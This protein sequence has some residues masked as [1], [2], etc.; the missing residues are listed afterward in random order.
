VGAVSYL[1]TKP[2]LYGIRNHPVLDEITL[3]E[4]YPSRVAQMLM[5]GRIDVGLIPVAATLKLP[6]WNI[7][8]SHCIGASGPVASVCLFSGQP[9][10]SIDTV[11]LDYQSRTSVNLARV[12]LRE[13]WKKDVQFIDA[14]GEDFRDKIRG[15]VA[16]VI[17]GD[18]ALEQRAHSAYIYDL[19]EAWI[20]HTGLPF[21][22]AAWISARPLPPSFCEAFDAANALGLAHLDE[23]ISA[24]PFAPYDLGKYYREN[25]DY[26]LDAPKKRG[27]QLF[28]EK[29]KNGVAV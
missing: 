3:V 17:I 22:F 11:Y 18:R 27:L 13:Y 2:L 12:L 21:V 8:G 24:H 5:E 7:V 6:E 10:E 9:V 25:I 15:S 19:A 23:V 4:D 14:R 28:L 29:L 20:D 26:Q 16:G 1:N